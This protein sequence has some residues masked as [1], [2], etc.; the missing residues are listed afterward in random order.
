MHQSYI[1]TSSKQEQCVFLESQK[2]NIREKMHDKLLIITPV[3]SAP[4]PSL[5][6]FGNWI[7]L[8]R[9]SVSR[10]ALRRKSQQI[11]RAAC[12]RF[13]ELRFSLTL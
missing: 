12:Y 7:F 1:V 3:T 6:F 11:T 10:L 13:P 4:R 5:C 9:V 2:S 8:A